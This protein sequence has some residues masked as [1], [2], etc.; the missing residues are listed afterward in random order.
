MNGRARFSWPTS[1]VIGDTHFVK[2]QA[3]DIAP[4]Q[5]NP[6]FFDWG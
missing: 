1:S 3:W 4:V 5:E 2:P 6:V